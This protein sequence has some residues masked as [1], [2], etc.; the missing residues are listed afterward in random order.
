[1][2]SVTITSEL[3]Q[4]ITEELKARE[5]YSSDQFLAL[6]EA[7]LGQE[8][9]ESLVF[10]ADPAAF[11]AELGELRSSLDDRLDKAAPPAQKRFLRF[12]T[13]LTVALSS[14]LPRW[15]LLSGERHHKPLAGEQLQAVI[16]ANK[17]LLAQWEA[18]V[19][20]LGEELRAELEAY[21]L[22]RFTAEAADT[23]QALAEELVDSSLVEYVDNMATAISRSNLRRIAEMRD[24]G[25]TRTE[26]GNDY[27][28]FLQ[29]T[30]YLGASFVTS[31]P[32][33]VDIAWVADPERWNPIMDAVVSANPQA[34]ESVLARLCTLEVVLANMKLLRPIFLLTEGQM[35]CVSLQVN[36][37]KH[38]DAESM[39]SDVCSI[40]EELKAKL[41]DGVPNVVFKL[42]GTRAGLEACR[43]VTR[44]G[45]GVNITVNF[46][47]FQQLPFAEAIQEGEAIFSCLTEMNGRL[48]YPVRDELLGKLEELAALGI[49]EAG[50]REAA[51]WSG[52][53]I[54]KRLEE[55]L[56]EKG[57]DLGKVRPL[58]ASLRIYEE[59]PGYDRLP[60]AFPDVTEQVGTGIIT[61]FPNVRHAFDEAGEIDLDARRV[62]A[63]VPDEVLETLIHSEL[64]K[65]AYYVGDKEWVAD[66]SRFKPAHELVLADEERVFGYPPI[67]ATL[68]QFGN[69]YDQF[70]QRILERKRS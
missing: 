15:N 24:A 36:P 6:V 53:A 67:N 54:V 7:G 33:L 44:E 26:L 31:N 49:D 19:P 22:S 12:L 41:Q 65:Q 45:I 35:G 1:M 30:M 8:V 25:Q 17:A 66:D 23:P 2:E 69:S 52:V 46:G 38:G 5:C 55:L 68:T 64:F 4:A 14:F 47:M 10:Y 50:A 59:G 21:A 60:S 37:K 62:E 34:D 3:R 40:Y 51:A 43:A 61:V 70:V 39:I 57:Y 56:A 42:P 18:R 28:A 58:V 29:Y 32:V 13:D 9:V 48:A 16:E 63:P 27:A 20:A 11:G